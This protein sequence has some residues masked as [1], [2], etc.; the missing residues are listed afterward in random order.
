MNIFI[1]FPPC[2]HRFL[3]TLPTVHPLLPIFNLLLIILP[4]HIRLKKVHHAIL[5]PNLWNE[6]VLSGFVC[7]LPPLMYLEGHPSSHVDGA[8]VVNLEGLVCSPTV[9]TLLARG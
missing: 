8:L 2:V 6:Y 4:P 5:L 3:P 7:Y 9:K 1:L